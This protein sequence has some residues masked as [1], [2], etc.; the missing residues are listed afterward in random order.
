M[1]A[2][3]LK[4]GA[5]GELPGLAVLLMFELSAAFSLKE[6]MGLIAIE[7]ETC[8]ARA[9]VCDECQAVMDGRPRNSVP[10]CP[11]LSVPL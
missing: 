11:C 2:L 9:C 4:C 8:G 6:Q 7:C 5:S 1:K 10:S 3:C